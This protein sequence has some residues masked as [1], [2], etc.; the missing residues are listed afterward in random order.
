MV[1]CDTDT[2][3]SLYTWFLSWKVFEAPQLHGQQMTAGIPCWIYQA[4][5]S[6]SVGSPNKPV[7]MVDFCMENNVHPRKLNKINISRW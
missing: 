2:L 4:G 1:E 5:V 6:K 7:I 3:H